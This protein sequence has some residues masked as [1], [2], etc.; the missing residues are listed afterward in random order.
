MAE[1]AQVE[2]VKDLLPADAETNGWNDQ[3][4][5]TYLDAGNSVSKTVALYWEGRAS[6]LYQ[7]IDIS[8]SGSSRSLSK[9]YDNAKSMAE[10]WRDRA[11][12]EREEAIDD[13]KA[14]TFGRIKRV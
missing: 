2:M 13:A 14:T 6:R 5:T 9:I 11:A 10:Y 1:A 3:K 8:E 7:M 12:A 4:I